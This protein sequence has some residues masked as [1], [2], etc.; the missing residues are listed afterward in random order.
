MSVAPIAGVLLTFAAGGGGGG[1]AG[2]DVEDE[3]GSSDVLGRT[4]DGG[5]DEVSAAAEVG[6]TAVVPAL[7]LEVAGTVTAPELVLASVDVAAAGEIPPGDAA[8]WLFEQ[9]VASRAAAISTPA[10][11]TLRGQRRVTASTVPIVP[12]V[13]L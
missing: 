10:A 11:A 13:P 7:S 8:P 5:A 6:A 12:V 2:V 1:G 9:A 4:L 3:V